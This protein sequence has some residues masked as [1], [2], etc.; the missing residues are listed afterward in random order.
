M[1]KNQCTEDEF[2][3]KQEETWSGFC[4]RDVHNNCTH[5]SCV[6]CWNREIY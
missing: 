6:E 1:I 4:P 5:S 2:W 3:D